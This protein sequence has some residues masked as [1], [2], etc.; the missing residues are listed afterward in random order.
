M[1]QPRYGL[2]ALYLFGSRAT[3]RARAGS[4]VDV[5]ALVNELPEP[6]ER[7]QLRQQLEDELGGSVDLVILNDAS[8]ILA[9]Q[10]LRHGQLIYDGSPG[11]RANFEMTTMTA[12]A[13]LK[14][15]RAP[16]ERALVQRLRDA[17]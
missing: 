17:G 13:D 9:W 8:P 4:D 7:L 6:L 3:G 2:H 15:A 10:V 11:I 12:Y 14:R 16:V 5:A 1:L